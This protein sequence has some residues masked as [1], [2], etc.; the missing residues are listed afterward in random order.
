MVISLK[1]LHWLMKMHIEQRGGGQQEVIPTKQCI[2]I[3]TTGGMRL[4]VLRELG[5]FE[6]FSHKVIMKC[7]Y[8][9]LRY[10]IRINF[11]WVENLY[12]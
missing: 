1:K 8:N 9:H 5:L 10:L 11:I 7:I 2:Q 12:D 3:M 4:S 6:L